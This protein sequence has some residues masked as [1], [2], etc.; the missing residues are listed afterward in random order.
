MVM[1]YVCYVSTLMLVLFGAVKV[2][3]LPLLVKV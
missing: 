2:T 1:P 3:V